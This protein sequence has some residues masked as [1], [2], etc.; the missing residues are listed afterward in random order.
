M[1][2]D[3][4]CSTQANET[5]SFHCANH[6]PQIERFRAEIVKTIFPAHAHEGFVFGVVQRGVQL[7]TCRSVKYLAP[8][9]S[10]ILLNP[11]EIHAAQ[12]ADGRSMKYQTLHVPSSMVEEIGGKNFRFSKPVAH[13]PELAHRLVQSFADLDATACTDFWHERLSGIL[14]ATTQML[15]E[16]PVERD[17]RAMDTRLQR[18]LEY[19]HEHIA[20]PLDLGL[21]AEQA[22]MSLFYFIR[23]FKQALGVTPHAYIQARRTALAKRMLGDQS[24]ADVAA[25][26]GFVDQSHLTRW[27][28]A[29]YGTTPGAYQEMLKGKPSP[30]RGA[31]AAGIN[32]LRSLSGA[33]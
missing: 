18:V 22:E 5:I 1:Q 19:I 17:H 14:V 4:G 28:K 31:G 23:C 32:R 9:D 15:G 6:R 30:P 3:Q 13:T 2:S 8:A 16:K 26:M 11:E 29:C 10:L 21:L 12:S 25:Q 7:V 33:G 27:L 20:S 24:A